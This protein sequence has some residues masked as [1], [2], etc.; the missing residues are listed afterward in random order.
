MKASVF[1]GH[2][3][4]LQCTMPFW[5]VP[6]EIQGTALIDT[7]FEVSAIS[8]D[9]TNRHHLV[10]REVDRRPL[11]SVNAQRAMTPIVE[12]SVILRP[13]R[14]EP[15]TWRRRWFHCPIPGVDLVVGMHMLREGR[16]VIFGERG[17]WRWSIRH[18]HF[19][20]AR[21]PRA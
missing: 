1:Q 21:C 15:I 20:R 3:E 18:E 11:S 13:Q 8:T 19:L 16:F 5:F 12:E 2:V 10:L 7:G 4:K 14:G 6:G 17:E 9:F